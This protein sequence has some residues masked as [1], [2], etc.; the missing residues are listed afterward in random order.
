MKQNLNA[1][2]ETCPFC[3]SYLTE[4]EK[5]ALASSQYIHCEKEA[6]VRD[7]YKQTK[8]PLIP[9]GI[10]EKAWLDLHGSHPQSADEMIAFDYWYNRTKNEQRKLDLQANML[11]NEL[12][13]KR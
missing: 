13:K 4:S 12:S 7:Y 9:D 2:E 5:E 6:Y 3:N 10:R 11:E 1:K 8:L